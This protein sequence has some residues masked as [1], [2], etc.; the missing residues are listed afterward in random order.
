MFSLIKKSLLGDSQ[1]NQT[2]HDIDDE[3]T[4][5][6]SEDA[7]G[8]TRSTK[9]PLTKEQARGKRYR[10]GDQSHGDSINSNCQK[11][12]RL[13]R[14]EKAQ[15]QDDSDGDSATV[16]EETRTGDCEKKTT[17]LPEGTPE[18]G[19]KLLEI[20][21]SDLRTWTDQ[22]KS[23]ESQTSKNTKDISSVE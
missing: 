17:K 13:K 12:S 2:S 7:V 20:I 1:S 5:T 15:L 10:S 4:H 21:Q 9:S 8:S 22:V 11:K 14:S 18:W 6:E 3:G 19:I 16:T 23:V